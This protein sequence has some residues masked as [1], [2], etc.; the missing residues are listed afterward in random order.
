LNTSIPVKETIYLKFWRW[1]RKPKK[2]KS[3]LRD[4]IET[5]II[6]GILALIIKET[7]I[8]AFYIPS[9][10]MEA[11]LLIDD[12][13]LVN[14]FIYKLTD[15]KRN[16]IIIFKFPHDADYPEPSSNYKK[17]ILLPLFINTK[18]SGILDIIKYYRP[19]DFIKRA[20][21][22]P[23]DTFEM[24][25]KIVYINGE[26]EKLNEA[27]YTS[28]DVLLEC[29]YFGSI[30]IPKKNDIIKFSELN[31]FELFCFEKY[32]EY[33]KIKFEYE[34]EYFIDSK[35]QEN[36]ETIFGM[37]PIKSIELR[38]LCVYDENNKH[39]GKK[40][41][42]KITKIM[43]DGAEIKEYKMP[44]DCY[45]AL[46]DNRDNSSDSRFWGFVPYSLIKGE[47]LVI[48]WPLTRLR[49]LF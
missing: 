15:V 26:K 44:E 21:G 33:K 16:D 20:I 10:S 42:F 47:P 14:R 2:E 3:A 1:L 32:F 34:F 24:R 29:D 39:S 27:I 31:I 8:Q 9:S 17:I 28:T 7:I 43:I 48:Y 19:R 36:I 38:R 40:T 18:P 37:Q 5:I 30:K 11:T 4:W 12:H 6:A 25:N 22:M 13:I 41:E 23:G 45:F 49:I 35:K 46:G